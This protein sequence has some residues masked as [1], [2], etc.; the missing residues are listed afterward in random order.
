MII[1][2]TTNFE[3][4]ASYHNLEERRLVDYIVFLLAIHIS[5]L[6]SCATHVN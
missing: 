3:W 5:S 1:V 6:K 4:I 2:I